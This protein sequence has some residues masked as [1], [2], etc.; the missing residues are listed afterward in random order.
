MR[1]HKATTETCN[2]EEGLTSCFFLCHQKILEGVGFEGLLMII[3]FQHL[4]HRQGHFPLVQ[5]APSY[6]QGWSTQKFSEQDL[7]QSHHFHYDKILIYSLSESGWYHLLLVYVGVSDPALLFPHFVASRPP[8]FF[9]SFSWFCS[10]FAEYKLPLYKQ[11]MKR[12]SQGELA[13]FCSVFFPSIHPQSL[14]FPIAF[15][16]ENNNM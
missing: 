1:R 12:N 2:K 4:C 7:P 8:R 3:L 15:S 5:D 13:K 10:S 11:K 6:F 9:L 14:Q 16:I